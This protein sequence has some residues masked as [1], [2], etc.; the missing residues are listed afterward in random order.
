MGFKR[1]PMSFNKGLSFLP[2]NQFY[3]SPPDSIS[4]P[5]NILHPAQLSQCLNLNHIISGQLTKRKG[6]EYVI[7]SPDWANS[8]ANLLS[9]FIDKAHGYLVLINRD[10]GNLFYFDILDEAPTWQQLISNYN[11]EHYFDSALYDS[12]LYIVNGVDALKKFDGEELITL[13]ISVPDYGAYMG[14]YPVL[15]SLS[16]E[17]SDSD[18]LFNGEGNGI[19]EYKAVFGIDGEKGNPGGIGRA[20]NMM[21]RGVPSIQ[22]YVQ[23]FR[24]QW[25]DRQYVTGVDL[26]LPVSSDTR[27]NKRIV[28]R[29]WKKYGDY[30]FSPWEKITEVKGNNVTNF[31]DVYESSGEIMETDN[32]KPVR[33]RFIESVKNH[34]FLG[35]ITNDSVLEQP[36]V[37]HIY[38]NFSWDFNA[39]LLCIVNNTSSRIYTDVLVEL[40]FTCLETGGTGIYL[41]DAVT[42][43][44]PSGFWGH[45]FI[46]FDMDGV[47]PLPQVLQN[48]QQNDGNV[49]VGVRFPELSPGENYFYVNYIYNHNNILRYN[50]IEE[51]VCHWNP[52]RSTTVFYYDFNDAYEGIS[53]D[54]V[55][56]F[57]DRV[58]KWDDGGGITNDL[59]HSNYN[60]TYPTSV[61]GP[62]FY[63][64]PQSGGKAVDI[65]ND[66]F[67][68]LNND[69]ILTANNPLQS[70][71]PKFTMG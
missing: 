63:G 4:A 41:P 14:N 8:K 68:P 6:V 60:P 65:A 59:I 23:S 51:A 62:K 11:T 27:V 67:V 43:G 44:N 53:G 52:I 48:F 29:R 32:D 21:F 1:I 45:G 34:V 9:F 49:I 22:S 15:D 30:P 57:R 58:R 56:T 26:K 55:R 37:T 61:N 31:K 35:H 38:P 13:G 10:N 70:S 7:L 18:A 39:R 66:R 19:W 64:N 28:Y 20:Y 12:E 24:H 46:C 69:E 17:A 71:L 5:D 25:F 16:I 50:S 3:L 2:N 47:T 33:A 42:E 36:S 40:K 54:T